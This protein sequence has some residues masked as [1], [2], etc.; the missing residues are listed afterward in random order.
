M[1]RGVIIVSGVAVALVGLFGFAIMRERGISAYLK[2]RPE[3]VV[4]VDVEK[5]EARPWTRAI[6]ATGR[7]EAVNG[8]DVAA[9]VAG[10]VV[11]ITFQSGQ[12]VALGASLARLD[13]D[14]E[15]A[16]LQSARA[17]VRLNTLT[18][19]RYRSLRRTDAASQAKLD[20]AEANLVMAGAEVSRLERT[21]EKK[22]I[23]APFS[24]VLGI[25]RL[26]IGQYVT[27]GTKVTTLQDLSA[28]L[29]DFSVSQKDLSQLSVGQTLEVS[30]DA[31]P[32]HTFIG[33]L[34]AIEP[35]IDTASGLIT[36][37]ATFPNEEGLLR[38]GMYAKARIILPS[39]DQYLVV[40]QPAINYSLYGDF[41]YVVRSDDKDA[42]R[43][44]QTAVKVLDRHDNLALIAGDVKPGETI[45]ASGAV[46][47]SN[48]SKVKVAETPVLKV[49]PAVG[50]D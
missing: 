37:Q 10:R 50:L 5:A 46:R 16:Q 26:D 7:L 47:L 19:Q 20:E 18:A 42:M 14:V 22:D 8:V 15:R 49:K 28:M 1:K 6:V 17:Q 11:A 44:Y 29:M 24:G 31:Y 36:A 40:P 12:T 33:R 48:G 9:E 41:I 13:T 35:K 27:A 2:N 43:A 32:M 23:K 4:A 45:V 34:S 30:V 25:N 38:P 3:P 39:E 21:I